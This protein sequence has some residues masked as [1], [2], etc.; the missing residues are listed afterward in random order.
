[1]NT[2]QRHGSLVLLT[3]GLAFFAA[4]C[5]PSPSTETDG[6]D[7][8]TGEQAQQPA[9]NAEPQAPAEVREEK[10]VTVTGS[11]VRQEAE[12]AQR[13][14]SDAAMIGAE[15]YAIQPAPMPQRHADRPVDRENYAGIDTNPV[16]R[17]V[18]NP[19]S[20]FSID[21]DTGSY[22][23]IR[24]MLR[25]GRLPPQDAVR[26]EEMINYFSYDY[27][28]PDADD[29]PFSVQVEQAVT[30]WNENTRLLQIGLQ[31]Y[32]P[33]PESIPASNLVFLLDVSGSMNSPD[34]L[35]LLINSMKMLTRELDEDDRVAV[36][37]YAGAS[38]LVLE[39]TPGNEHAAISAALDR[40]S[41]GGSTNGGAGIELAYA[42]ARQGFI[43]G[44][45][46]RVIL[47]TDGDFNVGTVDFDSLVD[48][49]ERQR[50]SG[51][52]LTTL[53]FGTG[54]YNDHLMEQLADA[55]NGNHAYIDNL[56]EARKVLVAE[57]TSTLMMIAKDVKIQIE[58]NPAV[59]AE[60]RLIG[61][62]N[63]MLEREDFNNDAVD[64]GDIGAGHTVTALYEIALV[65]SGG[66]RV[67]PLRYQEEP[68]AGDP[69]GE[70]AF[71]RLRY[72]APDGDTSRLIEQPILPEDSE[73]SDRLAFAASVAAFGQH[74]RGGQYLEGFGLDDILA[75]A[76]PARGEDPFGYR[77]EFLQLVRLA[78]SQSLVKH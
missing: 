31:G 18:E 30:P 27:P 52:A 32:R 7:S 2:L 8:T 49:V 1:M 29:A 25:E 19:V 57:L 74:L 20:T 11:R 17:V 12:L 46:N 3:A 47:A 61:Y 22:S 77:A 6:T 53:G 41:A 70:L 44:G 54:N 33:D 50:E 10:L 64:A 21:V 72:K 24:R 4:G 58:F 38:G 43:E 15:S 76:T 51:V 16:H 63:R 55:G 75:L 67:D 35:P 73:M 65:G 5:A 66:E 28:V 62:E 39:S 40:L 13:A 48:L 34:K 14:M 36:V 37:V 59:V 78:D 69:T 45:V 60:Y 68:V 23:N 42:Q 71:L 9:L 26:V 56:N